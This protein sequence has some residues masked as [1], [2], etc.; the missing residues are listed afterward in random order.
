M[1][2]AACPGG[3]EP[4]SKSGIIAAWLRSPPRRR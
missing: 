4:N 3:D 2:A 1:S